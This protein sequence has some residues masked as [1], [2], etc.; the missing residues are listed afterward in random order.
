MGGW[1]G[2]FPFDRGNRYFVDRNMS[3]GVVDPAPRGS[4][5]RRFL[6]TMYVAGCQSLSL[7]GISR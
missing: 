5:T 6:T 4:F 3:Y 2:K 1:A 7:S